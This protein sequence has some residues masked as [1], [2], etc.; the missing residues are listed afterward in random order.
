[1]VKKRLI[2]V[3]KQERLSLYK[4]SQLCI[5]GIRHR[6]FRSVLTLSVILLAVAF[7]MV[8]LS[9]SSYLSSVGNGVRNEIKE[10]RKAAR[11]F[12][13]LYLVPST[14]DLAT[15]LA[16]MKPA[17]IEETMLTRVLDGD[18]AALQQLAK[19]AKQE[20]IYL[21]FFAKMNAGK[22]I[23]LVEDLEGRDIFSA[24]NSKEKLN[25][26]NLKL[27]PMVSLKLPGDMK[28]FTEFLSGHSS[29]LKE[30]TQLRGEIKSYSSEIN[31]A[32]MKL[33]S[34]AEI[35]AWLVK[36][37]DA[38]K[39][40]FSQLLSSKGIDLQP[41]LIDK[42]MLILQEN[43]LQ[44]SVYNALNEPAMRESWKKIFMENP[45][46]S[47]KIVMC[48]DQ[49]VA[50]MLNGAFTME[51]LKLVE[52]KVKYE[53]NLLDLELEL[54][55]KEISETGAFLSD[56]QIFLLSISFLVCM[57]G[58][59][60]AM[61]MSITERFREIATMKCLG[62]TDGFI[63]QQF[64]I[65]AGIQGIIGGLVG[66]VI[67]FIISLIQGM[68]FYGTYVWQ[69]FP[70]TNICLSFLIA[71]AAGIILAILASL[72]PSWSASR[73]APMEAMRIE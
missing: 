29:Y 60:N 67:G 39:K 50:D 58:I 7:F 22:R 10:S 13:V 3:Q 15:M 34:G 72:Y 61:L 18:K 12:S 21:N 17:S 73:M 62:A 64:M 5:N 35:E 59:A 37:G 38:G 52:E 66:G 49:Q 2:D 57:V 26:L 54:E 6:I 43:A 1:M 20:K 9:E 68:A 14:L 41:E 44:Q 31:E 65:E 53:R 24:V 28:G 30:L 16:D 47:Q 48:H 23:A 19:K 71:F 56:R 70:K 40:E 36:K 46:V 63:L 55:G 33:T 25:D 32:T 27:Q 4:V 51:Q 11:L 69:Y 42:V 8:L 45:P